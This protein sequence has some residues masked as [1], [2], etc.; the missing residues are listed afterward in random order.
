MAG[1]GDRGN[2]KAVGVAIF[3]YR[4]CLIRRAARNIEEFA[5][6]KALHCALSSWIGR[7]RARLRPVLAT[8]L[9]SH[10]SRRRRRA[11]KARLQALTVY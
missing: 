7:H 5:R 3:T 9:L 2:R 10:G 8:C 1:S 4:G 6:H 11:R